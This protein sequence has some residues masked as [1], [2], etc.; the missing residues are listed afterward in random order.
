M[1]SE[2]PKIAGKFPFTVTGDFNAIEDTDVYRILTGKM[3]PGK[4]KLIDA[5]YVS[6]KGHFGG[7]STW[8]GF[9]ELEPK[10]KI[11]YVFVGGKLRVLEHGILSD[12]WEGLWASD[13]LPVL[14]EVVF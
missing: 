3:N 9:K 6:E 1:L 4:F 12:R 14:A 5:R 7:I 11:D 8:N 2:I 13:H 10:R